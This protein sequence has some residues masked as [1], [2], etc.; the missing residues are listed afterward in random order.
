[1]EGVHA[2]DVQINCS[3]LFVLYNIFVI[4]FNTAVA[5][6]NTSISV[7]SY[8]IWNIIRVRCTRLPSQWVQ[9]WNEAMNEIVFILKYNIFDI[10]HG[11][12]GVCWIEI[13][14]KGIADACWVLPCTVPV[15]LCSPTVAS[16]CHLHEHGAQRAACRSTQTGPGLLCPLSSTTG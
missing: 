8:P 6:K 15:L 11:Y 4:K 13:G 16:G 1:M 9:T 14:G 2:L 3:N 10:K 7:G 12:L 5:I